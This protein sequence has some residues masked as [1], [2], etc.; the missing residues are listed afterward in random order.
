MPAGEH[1]KRLREKANISVAKAA[2]LVGVD[3]DRWRKWEQRNADPKDSG[4]TNKILTF[5]QISEIGDL[6]RLENFQFVPNKESLR[7]PGLQAVQITPKAWEDLAESVKRLSIGVETG[8]NNI[9]T[10]LGMMGTNS[11]ASLSICSEEE[12]SE[13][14]QRIGQGLAQDIEIGSS[15]GKFVAYAMKVLG[16]IRGLVPKDTRKPVSPAKKHTGQG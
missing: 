11:N 9:S 3:A 16:E 5:F 7:L 4:D 15:P 6:C 13:W 1:L 8:Q 10:I 2:D 14:L 12:M